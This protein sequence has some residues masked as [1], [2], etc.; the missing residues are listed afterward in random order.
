M[1]QTSQTSFLIKSIKSHKTQCLK[2]HKNMA[3][4][5]ET[6]SWEYDHFNLFKS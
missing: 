5:I 6:E 2:V 3:M 4:R 1:T